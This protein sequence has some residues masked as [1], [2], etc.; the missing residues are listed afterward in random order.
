VDPISAACVKYQKQVGNFRKNK[1]KQILS[2]ISSSQH[3]PL[4]LKITRAEEW[5]PDNKSPFLI[6][7]RAFL[8]D[9]DDMSNAICFYIKE[10]YDLVKKGFRDAAI[11]IPTFESKLQETDD[12]IENIIAHCLAFAQTLQEYVEAP[13]F[14]WFPTNVHS[15]SEWIDT[16]EEIVKSLCEYGFKCIFLFGKDKWNKKIEKEFEDKVETIEFTIDDQVSSDYFGKLF[17]SPALGHLKGTPSGSAAPDVTPP[18]RVVKMPSDEQIKS[19]MAQLNLPPM[20]TESQAEQLRINVFE[21]AKASANKD[22]DLTIAK[23][24]VACTICE[25]AGVKLE[26]SLMRLTLA[27]YYLQFK[28]E[29]EAIKE[30]KNAENLAAEIKAYVQLAQIRLALAFVY[31]RRKKTIEEAIHNYEQAAVA[32]TIG[33]SWILYLEAL[34]M[35]GTCYIKNHD[36]DGAMLCWQ[37]AI[38]KGSKINAE[39]VRLSSFMDTAGV[40]MKLLEKNGLHDQADSVGQIVAEI[41]KEPPSEEEMV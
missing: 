18:E 16:C 32:A 39:E 29:D 38:D 3:I 11:D 22:K 2:V 1:E 37:A 34:R 6:T 30:Y 21:A 8:K 26:H 19:A 15:G 25:D 14:C 17:G 31:N 12:P 35:A 41:G 5:Q 7:D 20:L 24:T 36:N 40:F 9:A 27:N 33:E 10:H 28:K 4:L 13:Y 23:Q